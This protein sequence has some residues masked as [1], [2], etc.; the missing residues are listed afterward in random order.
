MLKGT[1]LIQTFQAILLDIE[2]YI[3]SRETLHIICLKIT[4]ITGSL[5]FA[6][7]TFVYI[8]DRVQ[9]DSVITELMHTNEIELSIPRCN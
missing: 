7:L 1:N 2:C 9:L 4:L 8:N 5:N 6:N 3:R